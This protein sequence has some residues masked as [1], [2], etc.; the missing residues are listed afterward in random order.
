MRFAIPIIILLF[1]EYYSYIAFSSLNRSKTFTILYFIITFLLYLYIGYNFYNTNFSKGQSHKS[2]FLM[3]IVLLIVLPKLILSV[4]MLIQDILR[5]FF[6]IGKKI[7]GTETTTFLPER[8][9]FVSQVALGIAA[10]PFLSIIYGMAKG[11]YNFKVIKQTIYFDDLP[12]AFDGFKITQISDIHSGSLD[13][14]E[15]IQ[16]AVDLINEQDSDVFVFTGDLVNSLAEEMNPWISILSKIKKH[17]FGNY[18]IL[19]NHDYGEYVKFDSVQAKQKNFEEIKNSHAKVGWRLLLNENVTFTKDNEIINLV[20]VENW[21]LKFKKAGDL[22]LASEG[23]NPETFKILLTHDPSHWEA[24]VVENPMNYGLTLSGHTH[25]MQFGIEIPGYFQW[26]PVKYVYP[27]W[28]GLYQ[29]A[30]NYIY[31]NRGFGFHAFAGRV[32][33]NPE[34]TVIELKK[35]R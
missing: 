34:I 23:L 31:V 22:P 29:K 16:Y 15:K 25:G 13:D 19:G 32:G 10:I 14:A 33:I 6:G 21:G 9:K 24:E 1:L 28:A 11:K 35:T 26:S 18:S 30:K 27:Q 8:R 2:M 7:A 4:P 3:S 5:V 17:P 20:G 12:E